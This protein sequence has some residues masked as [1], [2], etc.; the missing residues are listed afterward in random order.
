M[1]KNKIILVYTCN[2]WKDTSSMTLC[3]ATTDISRVR[4][5]LRKGLKENI[6]EYKTGDEASAQKQLAKLK[7]YW[8]E[9]FG[10]DAHGQPSEFQEEDLRELNNYMDYVF[11]DV[12]EDGDIDL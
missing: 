11:I 9:R 12:V 1:A 8:D 4:T 2:I 3:M 6:F 10:S 5:A 7:Q